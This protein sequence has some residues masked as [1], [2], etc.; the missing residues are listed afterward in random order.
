MTLLTGLGLL[1]FMLPVEAQGE[2]PSAKE[3][4]A[5]LSEVVEDGDSATRL[6][7]KVEPA[8]GGDKIVLQLQVKARRS[9]EKTEVLY[10]VLWPKANKGQAF[11]IQ[12]DRGGEP[13]GVAYNPTTKK[14]TPLN[15]ANMIDLGLGSGQASFLTS[16]LETPA[17]PS[18]K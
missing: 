5:R 10:Q 11:L 14:I 9:A 3:L 7:L 17:L 2:T 6:R 13:K 18:G 16:D 1:C 8:A 12:Q 4:A 15:K